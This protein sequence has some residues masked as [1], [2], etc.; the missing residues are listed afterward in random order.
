[1]ASEL[2]VR[3]TEGLAADLAPRYWCIKSRRDAVIPKNETSAA[4]RPETL[5]IVITGLSERS[6]VARR[7]R[8]PVHAIRTSAPP[9]AK[10]VMT[11]GCENQTKVAPATPKYAACF[12]DSTR[13]LR[14]RDSQSRATAT[15]TSREYC[16]VS[17][18]KVTR[19]AAVANS[20]I[21]KTAAKGRRNLLTMRQN[22]TRP[23]IED[24]SGTNLNA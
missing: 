1:M 10:T 21:A 12:R 11:A 22:M 2:L 7:S 4:A 6:Q 14:R 17:E 16:L 9:N 5:H 15:A 20:V 18:P 24:T 8:E 3:A 13:R 19:G 23:A